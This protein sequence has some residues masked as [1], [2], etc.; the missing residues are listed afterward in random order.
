MTIKELKNF[1]FENYYKQIGFT[2]KTII[3]ERNMK[4]KNI[5]YCLKLSS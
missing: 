4:R 3:I 5:F 1:V 2:K